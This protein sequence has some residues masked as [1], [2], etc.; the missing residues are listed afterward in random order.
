M[1]GG[2]HDGLYFISVALSRYMYISSVSA[3]VVYARYCISG[4]PH[5][6]TLRYS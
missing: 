1:F 5:P 3:H 4:V 6:P 2:I